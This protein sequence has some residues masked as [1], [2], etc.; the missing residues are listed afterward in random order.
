MRLREVLS[1]GLYQDPDEA[2]VGA[3][4]IAMLHLDWL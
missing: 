4:T 2:V 3:G 1:R